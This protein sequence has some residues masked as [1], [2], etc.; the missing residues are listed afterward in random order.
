MC[1]IH[2]MVRIFGEYEFHR[3]WPQKVWTDNRLLSQVSAAVMCEVMT[4]YRTH[5]DDCWDACI[6]SWSISCRQ[7]VMT[8]LQLT[9]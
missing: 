5:D 9:G 4:M 7:N 6:V 2:Y 3:W 1:C 8:T